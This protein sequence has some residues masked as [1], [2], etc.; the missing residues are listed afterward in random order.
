MNWMTSGRHRALYSQRGRR[1]QMHFPSQVQCQR[2]KATSPPRSSHSARAHDSATPWYIVPVGDD[3]ESQ[4]IRVLELERKGAMS[5]MDGMAQG[6]AR[7]GVELVTT[8]CI[9][10]GGARLSP[11]YGQKRQVIPGERNENRCIFTPV[12]KARKYEQPLDSV[13]QLRGARGERP[14]SSIASDVDT[15]FFNDN[16]ELPHKTR[17]QYTSRSYS[18]PAP[19]EIRKRSFSQQFNGNRSCDRLGGVQ[20]LQLQQSVYDKNFDKGVFASG[21]CNDEQQLSHGIHDQQTFSDASETNQR[22]F[23]RWKVNSGSYA[24]FNPDVPFDHPE[25]ASFRNINDPSRKKV[26][27][28]PPSSPADASPLSF[29]MSRAE[30]LQSQLS[31]NVHDANRHPVEHRMSY[32]PI[33]SPSPSTSTSSQCSIVLGRPPLGWQKKLMLSLGDDTIDQPETRFGSFAPSSEETSPLSSTNDVTANRKNHGPHRFALESS[34]S[35]TRSDSENSLLNAVVPANAK[36]H[37]M[38]A[39]T[40]QQLPTDSRMWFQRPTAMTKLGETNGADAAF[41]GKS[42]ALQQS[43]VMSSRT[44]T[45]LD[46][47]SSS[48]DPS[49]ENAAEKPKT[50]YQEMESVAVYMYT[51]VQCY[52]IDESLRHNSPIAAQ[53][54]LVREASSPPAATA[55]ANQTACRREIIF[56]PKHAS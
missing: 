6:K 37:I 13:Q 49:A 36:E 56:S 43:W 40:S 50:K 5:N 31:S 39:A 24:G 55:L 46:T 1:R 53:T 20:Q 26:H 51:L 25:N 42:T 45:I 52:K 4:D 7:E 41:S 12:K 10:D 11:S 21:E 8:E 23:Q 33:Q 9:I 38:A 17:A 28:T 48:K 30:V 44:K 3:N 27:G 54:Q 2:V 19:S 16:K 29:R 15:H 18:D 47:V 34:P 32:T 35:P 14:T 22:D